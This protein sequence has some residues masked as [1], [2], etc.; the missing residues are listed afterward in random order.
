MAML[1]TGAERQAA[2][3][4]PV[5]VPPGGFESVMPASYPPP[6]PPLP[7][8]AMKAQGAKQYGHF[9][10]DNIKVNAMGVSTT[11]K[12]IK[13]MYKGDGI[14]ADVAK[15]ALSNGDSERKGDLDKLINQ[16]TKLVEEKTEGKKEKLP[17][18]KADVAPPPPLPGSGTGCGWSG[19]SC[20]S[21]YPTCLPAPAAVPV[22]CTPGPP[23]SPAPE[24]T[25][26]R[27]ATSKAKVEEEKKAAEVEEE[28]DSY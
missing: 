20:P 21:A 17:E 2:R 7:C 18:P 9:V 26:G 16:V 23:G 15:C 11:I 19:S 27:P 22:P 28:P 10:I 5:P 13:F 25:K 8:P 1:K 4:P 3:T 14:E 6:P 12:K 24:P